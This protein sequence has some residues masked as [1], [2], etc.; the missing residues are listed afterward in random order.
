MSFRYERD[1]VG[2]AKAW[3]ESRGLLTKTEFLTPWGI[4]DLVGC[5][6]NSRNASKRMKLR[7][8]STMGSLT[9]VKLFSLMPDSQPVRMEELNAKV[10]SFISNGKVSAEMR[11]LVVRRFVE[12]TPH[13]AFL[14]KDGWIPL[15][16]KIVALELKLAR[17]GEAFDQALAHLE[18]ADESYV[19]YPAYIAK[20][21]VASGKR[22]AFVSAG[23]GVLAVM[24]SQCGI[25]LPARASS[26]PNPVVQTYLVE[27]FWRTYLRDK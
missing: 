25:L 5:S 8:T 26:S 10:G 27:R 18:F 23:I 14:K 16:K 22:Q 2:P 11:E 19:G 12:I 7:Q 24:P 9:R 17:I 1:M 21:V 3:L 15:Q 4:C 13:G 20:R 6:L